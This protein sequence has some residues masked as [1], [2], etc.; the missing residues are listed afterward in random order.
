MADDYYAVISEGEDGGVI[1]QFGKAMMPPYSSETHPTVEAAM[2]AHPGYE[3]RDPLP[4]EEVA[5]DVL[6]IGK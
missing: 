6:K 5:G 2:A 1:I 4:G 3:W